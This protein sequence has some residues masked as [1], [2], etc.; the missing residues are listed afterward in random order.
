MLQ[1]QRRGQLSSAP[2]S[3]HDGSR[4]ALP[5]AE[6]LAKD[7][8]ACFWIYGPRLPDA[9]Q[10]IASWDLTFKAELF[11]WTKINQKTGLPQIGTGKTTRKTTENAWLATRGKGLPILDHGVSQSI[12]VP[13]R[14]HSEKPDEAYKSLERLFGDNVRRLDLFARR[15]RPGLDTWR[16]EIPAR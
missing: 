5:L 12:W 13:R 15:A 4:G 2:L 7:V 8:A 11:C 16:N 9:L 6:I 3:I 1:H 14:A 10:V